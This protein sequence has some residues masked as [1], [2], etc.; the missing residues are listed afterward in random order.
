M[1][2]HP[3]SNGKQ[4]PTAR[5]IELIEREIRHLKELSFLEIGGLQRSSDKSEEGQ[6]EAGRQLAIAVEKT[7]QRVREQIAALKETLDNKVDTS[8][9]L[10]A[11]NAS[12]IAEVDRDRSKFATREIFDAYTQ[13]QRARAEVLAAAIVKS[14]ADARVV[15]EDL[16]KAS[17]AQAAGLS[18]ALDKRTDAVDERLARVEKTYL[19][20]EV[21]D[22]VIGAWI[23]WR[24]TVDLK[25]QALEVSDSE[26]LRLAGQGNQNRQLTFAVI[27]GVIGSLVGVVGLILALTQ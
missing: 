25:L 11:A 26:R 20:R 7:E 10:T 4:D 19:P 8:A 22:G 23:Q 9:A 24:G 12:K 15:A 3:I 27:F 6:H 18:L 14:Q 13:E 16:S 17:I 2:E 1:G 5:S 21:F